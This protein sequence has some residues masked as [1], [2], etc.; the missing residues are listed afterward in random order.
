MS[1]LKSQDN[2]KCL[3]I[4]SFTLIELLV[5]I[6]IIA[7]LASMLLPALNQARD[8]AKGIAC[9]NNLKQCG[10]SLAFYVDDYNEFYPA[11]RTSSGYWNSF[12]FANNYIAEPSAGQSSILVCPSVIPFVYKNDLNTYALWNGDGT[13]GNGETSTDPNDALAKYI[14][15]RKVNPER[16]LLSE[17]TRAGV[18]GGWEQ[19][20]YLEPGTGIMKDSGSPK[21]LQLI[22]S[23]KVNALFLDNCVR[24][25]EKGY[26]I[27]GGR[28]DYAFLGR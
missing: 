12:M 21:V 14:N 8:K 7:I 6:A 25:V 16:I 18:A 3:I 13:N 28:Y 27:Q 15:R 1:H 5:V 19:V 26:I 20:S 23:N 22:H 24:S 9:I 11:G 10:T 4:N 17:A 2:R